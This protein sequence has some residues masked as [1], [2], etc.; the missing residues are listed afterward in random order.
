MY[1]PLKNRICL[2]TPDR[3][4]RPELLEHC[5]WQMQQQTMGAGDHF[6]VNF[7]GEEGV[8]DIV[9]RI[10]LGIEAAK[11]HGYDYCLIIE[12]D[13]YYPNDYIE[14]MNRYFDYGSL[15]GIDRTVLYSIQYPG[16]RISSHPG[17]ASL[18]CTGFKISDLDNFQWPDDTTLYF[19]I[20]LWLHRCNK[21]FAVLPNGPIGIKHGT[22]FCPGNFHNGICNGK[23]MGKFVDDRSFEWLKSQ[24]RKKS[25]DFYSK[26]MNQ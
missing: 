18:F 17:R 5:I 16:Y 6:V 10:K 14:K 20:P 19:D 15:I 22:G 3:N 7:P 26:L 4:D 13:D 9:P 2:I 25:F 8:V 12:N 11:K 1:S 23:P 24:V 21:A